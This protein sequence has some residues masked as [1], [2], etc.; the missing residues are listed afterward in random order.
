MMTQKHFI[1]ASCSPQRYSL[2][3]QIGYEP[4]K[5]EA[6]DIDETPHKFEKPTEYVKR[7]AKGKALSVAARYEGKVILAGDTV[8]VVGR[9][10]LQK[11]SNS[12]EQVEIMKLLSGK[13]HKVLSGVCVVSETGKV[14]V[15]CVSTR[16][17]MK[18]LTIKE[19][20][21]YVESNEWVGCAGYKIE[22]QLAG[23]VKKMIGSYSSVVGLPLFEVKNML[24]GAGVR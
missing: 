21:D 16:I 3:K 7:M 14:S 8:V 11:A 17:L 9:R 1:L 15:R 20:Y 5:V 4:E 6:A 2:L 22:G 23:F 24:N 10:I 19:I 12:Q 13:S 18:K